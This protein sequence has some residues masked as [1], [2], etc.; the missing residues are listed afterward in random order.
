MMKKLFA[1]L[2]A[3]ALAFSAQAQTLP[4]L[5]TDLQQAVEAAQPDTAA[6]D[7][8]ESEAAD[9]KTQAEALIAEANQKLADAAAARTPDP[10]AQAHILELWTQIGQMLGIS[11]PS[12]DPVP[13]PTPTGLT[14]FT[15]SDFN[16]VLNV[17]AGHQDKQ[18]IGNAFDTSA[19]NVVGGSL[20]FDIDPTR[21]GA[22][23]WKAEKALMNTKGVYVVNAKFIDPDPG[24]VFAPL[25][26]YGEGGSE[27]KGEWD[28]E[29]MIRDGAGPM[30]DVNYHFT[31]GSGNL[32]SVPFDVA[33]HTVSYQI[34]RQPDSV[35]MKADCLDCTTPTSFSRTYTPADVTAK[36]WPWIPNDAAM[37]PF[38]EAWAC[39]WPGWCGTW[40]QGTAQMEL[41]GY[42][43]ETSK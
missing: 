24:Q 9:L 10:A 43:F 17:I 15:T 32:D 23:K 26:L 4:E 25:W 34:I 30:L 40:A 8:L 14:E 35:T 27:P 2:A 18:P 16:T 22:I 20:V 21:S 39:K 3:L 11:A 42:K 37:A 12:P 6:A 5:L 31:G 28:F 41:L 36:G 7:Q 19:V 38:A 29:W 1:P 33:G 13:V